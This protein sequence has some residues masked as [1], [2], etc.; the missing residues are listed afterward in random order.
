MTL[1]P[2]QDGAEAPKISSDGAHQGR[3]R[4]GEQ[5]TR[6]GARHK[7]VTIVVILVARDHV[8]DHDQDD[9]PTCWRWPAQSPPFRNDAHS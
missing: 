6:L 7:E 8:L 1:P 2:M 5:A 9:P 3:L 4:D